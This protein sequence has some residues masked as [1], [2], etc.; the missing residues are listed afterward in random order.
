[1]FRP[2]NSALGSLSLP[3]TFLALAPRG[4]ASGSP[5][6]PHLCPTRPWGLDGPQQWLPRFLPS[7]CVRSAS[8]RP[9]REGRRRVRAEYVSP[10]Q[11]T[12]Q[13]HSSIRQPSAHSYAAQFA[14]FKLSTRRLLHCAWLGSLTPAYPFVRSPSRT[15]DECTPATA[16][17]DT[18]RLT[19]L[20]MLWSL[21]S[22]NNQILTGFPDAA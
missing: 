17:A 7:A 21:P 22:D 14:N 20:L 8:R 3:L 18:S 9:W 16:L 19:V 2:R 6:H 11:S 13:K 5:E 4:L 12:A 15:Q 10:L 1:M